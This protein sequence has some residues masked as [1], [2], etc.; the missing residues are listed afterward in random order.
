MES[1]TYLEIHWFLSDLGTANNFSKSWGRTGTNPIR[2]NS[3]SKHHYPVCCCEVHSCFQHGI[4]IAQDSRRSSVYSTHIHYATSEA[5]LMKETV[6]NVGSSDPDV[7]VFSFPRDVAP[8][9]LESQEKTWTVGMWQMYGT[10]MNQSN[11]RFY[12]WWLVRAWPLRLLGLALSKDDGQ[13]R[14][15]SN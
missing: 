2:L 11:V 15:R 10:L 13:E 3:I 8:S 14:E 4:L 1:N 6:K 7:N 5:L 12:N 9:N